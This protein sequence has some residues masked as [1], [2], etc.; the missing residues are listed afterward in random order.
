M[1]QNPS[2]N[3]PI[4][5]SVIST[6]FPAVDTLGPFGGW[7]KRGVRGKVMGGRDE[8]LFC[9]EGSWDDGVRHGA[10]L[11]QLGVKLKRASEVANPKPKE[12]RM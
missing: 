8:E 10:R 9:S 7:A 4:H 5:T 1:V 6:I 12:R 3:L 2:F 11:G